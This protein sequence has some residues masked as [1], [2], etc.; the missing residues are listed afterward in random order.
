[1]SPV[2][3]AATTA[4]TNI[5]ARYGSGNSVINENTN[6]NPVVAPAPGRIPIISPYNVPASK[7]NTEAMFF[8]YI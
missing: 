1:V 3:L 8:P 2:V 7:A 4:I 5:T 6:I